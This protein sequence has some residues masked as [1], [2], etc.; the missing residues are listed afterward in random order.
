MEQPNPGHL[1][2]TAAAKDAP[3]STGTLESKNGSTEPFNPSEPIV[4]NRDRLAR[5]VHRDL[6]KMEHGE[7]EVLSEQ[8]NAMLNQLAHLAGP[9]PTIFSG[10]FI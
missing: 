5:I 10:Q 4:S 7:V 9:E 6:E 3:R 8:H 2:T 1:D